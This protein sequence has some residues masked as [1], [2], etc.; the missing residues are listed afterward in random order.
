[1]LLPVLQAAFRL[2][3]GAT[4][5][6]AVLADFICFLGAYGMKFGEYIE[7]ERRVEPERPEREDSV[8]WGRQTWSSVGTPAWMRRCAYSIF[9]STKRSSAPTGM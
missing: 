6:V 1:M 9:S 3:L 7:G 2:G 8:L 4:I 5:A